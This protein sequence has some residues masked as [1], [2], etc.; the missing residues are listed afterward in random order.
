MVVMRLIL[1]VFVKLVARAERLGLARV[2]E[3]TD[4]E[5]LVS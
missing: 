2:R 3:V 4:T 1:F 5:R